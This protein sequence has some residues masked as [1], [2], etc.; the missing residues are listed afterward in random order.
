MGD[1]KER[2]GKG[3]KNGLDMSK[4]KRAVKRTSSDDVLDDPKLYINREIAWVRFNRRILEEAQ[5]HS[6]PLLE[7]VKF[8]AICG[9]NLDEFFMVR[10]S[11]LRRQLIKGA[12]EP[13]PDGLTPLEQITDLKKEI[14]SMVSDYSALWFDDL[15]PLLAEEGIFVHDVSKLGAREKQYLREFFTS[16]IFPALTP[17]ALDLA[18]PFPFISNLSVNLAVSLKDPR[19]LQKYARVKVPSTL[20]NRFIQIPNE[21]IGDGKRKNDREMHFALLEDVIEMN[22]DILFPGM[23][24]VGSYPFRI[25]RDADIEIELDEAEDLLTAVEESVEA[26]RIGAPCRLEVERS[27]PEKLKELFASKLGLPNY[28]VFEKD[29]PLA[30]VDFWYLEIGRASCRERV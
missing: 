26:R 5:D 10:V 16:T 6:H 28:L 14:Q 29:Y 1:K 11:G 17:L 8:L 15:V 18:H 23:E 24:I 27:M 21:S 9:S 2:P 20:F 7:R 25:T 12:L 13:P 30:L 22:L 3:K 19:G 4:V